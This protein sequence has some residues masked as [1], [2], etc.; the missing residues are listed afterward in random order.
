MTEELIETQL[1]VWQDEL[2]H[3]ASDQARR[4]EYERGCREIAA[5][6]LEFE[7]ARRDK[8]VRYVKI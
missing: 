8:A 4:H 3:M 1:R 7:Q 5:A 2:D 6:R